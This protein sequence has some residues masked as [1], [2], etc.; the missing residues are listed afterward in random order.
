MKSH[1]L[2]IAKPDQGTVNEDAAIATASV[3]AISDGAGGGGVFADLWARYLLDNLPSAPLRTFEELD[4][5]IDGIWEPFF[6]EREGQAK[7]LGD[8]MLLNKF[9]DEGSFATLA[10]IW[11][12]DEI[13]WATYGDSVAFHYDYTNQ[14]LHSSHTD[15]TAFANAPLL[16]SCKDP[17][18]AEGFKSG[19]FPKSPGSVYFVASDALAHY[20]LMMYKVSQYGLFDTEV[21]NALNQHNRNSQYV[22]SAMALPRIHFEKL[23][24][25]LLGIKRPHNF[26]QHIV[27]LLNK[28]LIALDDCS[29]AVMTEG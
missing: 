17:L 27:S 4:S 29:L 28:H 6:N 9:Y 23:L 11:L 19:T 2:S 14:Q 12:G 5:W 24:R 16:I 25:K 26:K 13:H 3:V 8:A 10:A 7:Q 21:E 18:Q 15:M 20:I 1:W 22:K